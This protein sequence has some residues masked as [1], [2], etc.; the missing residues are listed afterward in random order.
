MAGPWEEFQQAPAAPVEGPWTQFQAAPA[1]E[2][3]WSAF[4]PADDG[5][6][7]Q[8]PILRNLEGIVGGIGATA[9][10]MLHGLVTIPQRAIEASQQDV[11]QMGSGEPIQA[12]EPAAEAAMAT[13]PFRKTVGGVRA[14]PTEAVPEVAPQGA[15]AALHNGK[16]LQGNPGETHADLLQRHGV[17]LDDFNPQRG[18]N[19]DLF[20]L[21]SGEIVNRNEMARRGLA[22]SGEDLRDFGVKPTP[23]QTAAPFEER[24]VPPPAVPKPVEAPSVAPEAPSSALES[25]IRGL[26]SAREQALQNADQHETFSNLDT[27]SR[28]Y[29]LTPDEK[30]GYRDLARSARMTADSIAR[31]I[32][33]LRAEGL[34]KPPTVPPEITA[35]TM[36]PTEPLR[37]AEP[38]PVAP[39]PQTPQSFA[40]DLFRLRQSSVADRAE[41]G[42]K[43]EALPP[44]LHDPVLQEKLYHAIE[45]PAKMAE[46]TPEERALFDQHVQPLMDEQA[47][48]AKRAKEL[49]GENLVG[50]A[51]YVHRIAKGH[52]PQYDSL[53]GEAYNPVTGTRGLPRTTSALQERAFYAIEDANGVR[54]VVSKD[55][56]GNLTVWND[57]EGTP[58][59]GDH[60]LISGSEVELGGKPWKVTHA[61]T[62][63]IEQHGLFSDGKGGS[64]PA[65]YYKNAV[66][67]TAD[68]VVRLR[69]VVRN[70]EFVKSVKESPWWLDHA[71]RGDGNQPIPPGWR[72]PKMPQFSE[73][74]V[75][76]KLADILDD[77]YKPGVLDAESAL[78]KINQFATGSIFWNPIPHIENVAAH[79]FTGRGWD[80]IKPGPM[81]NFAKDA[82]RAIRAVVSQNKDYQNFLRE[83]GGLV[84]GGV[85][86]GEFYQA[87]GRK[88]GMEIEKNWGSWKPVFDKLGLK[89]PYEAVA[90]WYNKM[91]NVLWAA[92][93]MFMMHR[94]LELE[95]QG[96]SKRAA[97][98]E[99]EKHIPNYRI[100]PKVL[101]SRTFSQILQEPGFTVFSRYHYGMWKSYMN[102][103][104]DL[105]K[106]KS[107]E[108]IDAMGNLA[109]LGVLMMGIYP[110]VDGALKMITGDE[111][112]KKLRR[113]SASIPTGVKEMYDGDITFPQFLANNITIAP[114]TKEI[115]QQATV[116]WFTGKNIGGVVPRVEHAAKGI[117]SPYNTLNQ[118]ADARQGT[119][120]PSRTLFD[121]V[122]G[123]KNTSERTE[124]GR[125]V[126]KKMRERLDKKQE[127]RPTGLLER[128]YK[129]IKEYGGPQ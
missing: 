20:R 3:P 62:S 40:D 128:G 56:D 13:M 85:K 125:E 74:Y 124:K 49:G 103:L 44:E 7:S 4:K 52:A 9:G 32:E 10:R 129:A 59:P 118:L 64:R 50:D 108:K 30:A 42:N 14:H 61:R 55:K 122:I 121:T 100:P 126:A 127:K 38:P 43:I 98:K 8:H 93:D 25:K 69:E 65:E 75:D 107:K 113:G 37:P 91:R 114:V 112:A 5:Y 17:N 67:N 23:E 73:W 88:F 96:L 11:Q 97:I 92:N 51:N 79:W 66:L 54:K 28:G 6:A 115:G 78:R 60:E 87:M 72:R 76:P 15:V 1:A 86:N 117:V 21:P 82:W 83:G 106:G 68:A 71:V 101:G 24:S 2:G 12:V 39:D 33:Q 89:T 105:A 29:A 53:S 110:A 26:E 109:A 70:L 116:D 94:Y 99:A 77:F 84:Y 16:L 19:I 95:R 27:E 47:A 18:D 80:W 35:E 90:W 57:R 120:S 123:A 119:R 48:L 58:I 81:R 31:S 36:R 41:V 111:K 22:E 102:M 34:P 63:E 45:D 46:L 104:G